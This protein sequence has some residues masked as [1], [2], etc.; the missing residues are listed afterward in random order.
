MTGKVVVEGSGREV[1]GE[2]TEVGGKRDNGDNEVEEEDVA[3]VRNDEENNVLDAG[4]VA[5]VGSSH[6]DLL[7]TSE[8]VEE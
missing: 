6:Q 2:N 8:P 4:E 1:A 3:S 7:I 5:D